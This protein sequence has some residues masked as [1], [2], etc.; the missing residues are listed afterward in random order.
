MLRCAAPPARFWVSMNSRGRRGAKRAA[1]QRGRKL[2]VKMAAY[3]RVEPKDYHLTVET[4]G[5]VNPYRYRYGFTGEL[6]EAFIQGWG[7]L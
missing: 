6:R 7:P 5:R 1:F 2:R 4:F 3:I